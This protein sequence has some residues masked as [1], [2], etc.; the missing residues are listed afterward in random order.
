MTDTLAYLL[1]KGDRLNT[2][3]PALSPLTMLTTLIFNLGLYSFKQIPRNALVNLPELQR[4]TMNGVANTIRTNAFVNLPKLQLI[5]VTNQLE[6][7][8]SGAFAIKQFN[9][10]SSSTST[11]Q[12]VTIDLS[13]NKLDENSFEQGFIQLNP[14]LNIT[15]DLTYNWIKFLPEDIFMPFFKANNG[16][17]LLLT[18]N[19]FEC[20]RC[21]SYWIISNSSITSGRLNVNCYMNNQL[22]IWDYDWSHCVNTGNNGGSSNLSKSSA[23]VLGVVIQL[24]LVLFVW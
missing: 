8:E 7:I 18:N 17:Q 9:N 20:G 16:N 3:F 13:N 21:N 24:S 11:A 12:V 22:T 10:D 15:L 6:S 4:V 2:V 23:V 5:K 14:E 19:K 1:I